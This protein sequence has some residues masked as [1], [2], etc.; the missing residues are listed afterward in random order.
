[1]ELLIGIFI[2]FIAGSLGGWKAREKA[3]EMKVNKYMEV[4]EKAK[5]NLS[6]SML[7]IEVHNEH[8]AFYIYNKESKA[9]ITQA[10][11]K[12]ELLDYFKKNHPDKNVIMSQ[13][14]LELF[15]KV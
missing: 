8:G 3:A 11:S 6:D 9:F 7:N 10:S 13:Q 5:E 12:E 2:G 1:M 14:D 15:D 4:L